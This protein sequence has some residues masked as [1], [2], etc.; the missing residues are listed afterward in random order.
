MEKTNLIIGNFF[1]CDI[2]YMKYNEDGSPKEWKTQK[3]IKEEIKSKY[4]N[5]ERNRII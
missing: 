3:E 2:E 1:F 5:H 4:L